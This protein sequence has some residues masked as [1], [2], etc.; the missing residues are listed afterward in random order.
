[1]FKALVYRLYPS[2]SQKARLEAVRETARH[3]YNDRLRERKDAYEQRGETITRTAQLRKVKVEK[4]TSPY[5]VDVH[6][7]TCK[8]SSPISTRHSRRSSAG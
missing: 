4:D 8:S 3:F 2:K 6:S 1:L 5:A 7:H